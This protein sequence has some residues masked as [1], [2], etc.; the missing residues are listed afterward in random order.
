MA[1]ES[2]PKTLKE[3]GN[4]AMSSEKFWAK[5]RDDPDNTLAKETMLSDA[6]KELVKEILLG[7]VQVDF[8]T[9]V[10]DAHKMK[11]PLKDEVWGKSWQGMWR[12]GAK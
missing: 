11:I 4:A 7:Q 3:L 1:R 12:F 9:L 10:N 8:K 2:E 6:D 5:L